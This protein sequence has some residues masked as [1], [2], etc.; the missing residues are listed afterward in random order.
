MEY[1]ARKKGAKNW[2]EAMQ[3]RTNLHKKHKEDL[4]RRI[5]TFSRKIVEKHPET[6]CNSARRNANWKKAE[7]A[8]V[9]RRNN[10]QCAVELLEPKSKTTRNQCSV[11]LN[12]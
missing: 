9:K 10:L 5:K 12:D 7:A 3:T 2:W 11:T 8:E 6:T 1:K 4:K